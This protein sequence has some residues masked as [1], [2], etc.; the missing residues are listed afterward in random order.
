MSN[1]PVS[2]AVDGAGIAHL[3]LERP[4][5]RNA[6]SRAMADEVVRCIDIADHDDGIKVVVISGSGADLSVGWD[7]DDVWPMYTEAPGG[8][9]RKVPSQRARMLALRDHWWGPNGL[10]ARVLR[11]TKVTVLQATGACHE[12]GLYLT[13]YC[14]LVIAS[15]DATFA[16]PRWRHLGVD[17]D[18]SVLIATVGLRRAKELFF[19]PQPWDAARALDAGLVDQVVS[20]DDVAG[21]AAALATTCASIMRDGIVTEKHAVAASLSRLGVDFGFSATNVVGALATNVHFRDGEFNLLREVSKRG[22]ASALQR[23]LDR[24]VDRHETPED[25]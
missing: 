14:D 11:C 8:S 7:I 23:D 21:A 4:E 17:G 13:L 5:Q 19:L 10:Y 6:V 24:R 3:R 12:V 22:A 16:N 25:T 9:A 18:M 15:D 20:R 1:P 2:F